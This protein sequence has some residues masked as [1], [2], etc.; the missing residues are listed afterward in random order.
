MLR[1]VKEKYE[2]HHGV[3]I[4]DDAIQAAVKLS[5]RYISDRFLPD[6]AVD[7][8]DEA[9]SALRMEIDSMPAEIES[10]Q[11]SVRRLEIEKKALQK[12]KNKDSRKKIQKIKR[13]L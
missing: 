10:F 5:Q 1:G 8:I 9:A 3:K 6:K 11:R 12:E 2:L 7:L 4:T 13:E